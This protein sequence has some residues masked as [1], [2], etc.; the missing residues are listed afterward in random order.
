[1][2]EELGAPSITDAILRFAD[3]KRAAGMEAPADFQTEET[4]RRLY[5]GLDLD[6]DEVLD[7]RKEVTMVALA[8]TVDALKESNLVQ[9][10]HI[11]AGQWLDGFVTGLMLAEL[12]AEREARRGEGAP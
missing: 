3:R 8:A 5:I 11:F 1:M 2:A 4:V 10:A 6:F 12:R 9:V 7:I